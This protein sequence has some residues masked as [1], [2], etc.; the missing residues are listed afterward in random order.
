MNPVVDAFLASWPIDPALWL[1]LL[2]PAI[3]YA[4]G[5]LWLRQR[6]PKRWQRRHLFC[7]LGGLSAILLA[8]GSPIEP[9]AFLFLQWH[10]TQHLLLTMAAP[11]LLWMSTPLFPMLRGLPAP[12]RTVW[13][14]P[15]LRSRPLRAFFGRLTHPVVALPV[16]VAVTWAW[17]LPGM[18]DLALR[19]DGWHY[20]QHAMFLAA[21]L[22]F[23]FPVIRPYPARPRWSRWLLFPYLILADVQNTALAALL[24]FSDRV[25][26]PHYATMPR[27]G[28]ISALDDQAGAG[29]IMWVPGS[30]AYLV[31]LFALALRA[32]FNPEVRK[33][34]G[35][36][37]LPMVQSRH[38][39]LLR[40]PIAGR[41]LKWKHARLV[42]QVPML[43]FAGLIVYDGFT[44][45][46]SAPINLAGVLP[47][48]HWRGFLIIGLLVIGNVFCMA[49]PF[50]LPRAL[51]RMVATPRWGWPG[52]RRHKWL[53]IVGIALFLW[54][55]EAFSLWDSP[56]LT[57][58][59]IVGYFI[60]ALVVDSLFRGA[61]FCKF[62]CPIGQF[63]FLQSLMSPWSVQAKSSA[64][65]S[66][67]RTKDC[68]RGNETSRGCELDLFVPHKHGNVDCTLC[69]DCIHACP[70]D[71][72]GIL[73]RVPGSDL[74]DDRMRSGLGRLTKR[75]DIAILVTLL[76][77][78]AFAN[79]AGMAAPIVA[80]QESLGISRMASVS[81]FYL[82][83]L[84]A[85]PVMVV[86]LASH[87]NL[88]RAVRFAYCLVP[89]GFAMWLAH[90]SFHLFTTYDAVIP[91]TQ[92]F[93]LDAGINLG[94]PDWACACCRPVGGWVLRFEL[95]A[96]DLGLLLSLYTAFRLADRSWRSAAP[97]AMLLMVMFAFGIWIMLQPMQMRG[98]MG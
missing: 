44:G 74:Y 43:A 10:M 41:F 89:L 12:I 8:L 40:I 18:Y 84:V 83:M 51:A 37:P 56:W 1:G 88:R 78:G 20:A 47:W 53:G 77:F 92:R 93:A 14:V 38:V 23:W 90:Y 94:Q 54:S 71:N 67:C 81:V 15:L 73:P 86:G 31:P 2:A 63:N 46:E 5:W 3:I 11:P 66:D 69:L 65:C 68:I 50:M 91:V 33:P 45:P 28:G 9:F 39:D 57:A 59:I 55:Y 42:M 79:A 64:I 27:L 60:T 16:Y 85:L 98:M 36:V 21:A 4:R 52:G 95:L 61:A 82:L 26:Y 96:L 49:C 48:V 7:F 29:V 24:T 17:H 32:L 19:S 13:V 97:W 58:W 34:A 76:F 75:T 80:W 22:I 30:I 25:I 72:I 70:H 6:D 35:R 87:F 62:V